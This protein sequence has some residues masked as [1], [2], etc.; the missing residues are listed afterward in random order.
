MHS[1]LESAILGAVGFISTPLVLTEIPSPGDGELWLLPG[2]RQVLQL[3]PGL[4]G[5]QSNALTGLQNHYLGAFHAV[6][7]KMSTQAELDIILVDCSPS[8]GKPLMRVIAAH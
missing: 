7:E 5:A 1:I 4:A 3:E 6:L 2:S 8:C